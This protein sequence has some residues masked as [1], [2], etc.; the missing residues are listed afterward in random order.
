[1]VPVGRVAHGSTALPPNVSSRPKIGPSIALP[2]QPMYLSRRVDYTNTHTHFLQDLQRGQNKAKYK[3]GH[4]GG[5][6]V[7]FRVDMVYYP[8][9]K[10]RP[11]NLGKV[12]YYCYVFKHIV[13]I[14]TL[15]RLQCSVGMTRVLLVLQSC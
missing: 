14:I 3:G 1:M 13:L 5:N 9:G 7:S 15:Y 4:D 8:P 6:A 10:N 12:C 2:D 11:K